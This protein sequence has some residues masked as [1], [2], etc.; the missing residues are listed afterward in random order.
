MSAPLVMP[1][2][3]VSSVT[4]T[5]RAATTM[6][7]SPFTFAQ[8]SQDWG[9]RMWVYEFDMKVTQGRE[10]QILSRFFDQLGGVTGRFLWIDQALPRVTA[11]E[12]LVDG[13]G[14][15]GASLLV[16]GCTPSTTVLTD[17]DFFSIGTGFE[18]RLYRVDQDIVS[19]ETGAATVTFFPALRISPAD[20]SPLELAS[21]SVLLR[22][23]RPVPADIR[24]ADIY[25]FTVQAQEAL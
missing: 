14:Q 9:G 18:T 8:Q 13:A 21:P 24:P 20:E 15:T 23:T 17:G 22:L 11:E 19:D 7:M 12:P 1:T 4:R 10:G 3:A 5:L 16:K 25:R 2:E 6:E